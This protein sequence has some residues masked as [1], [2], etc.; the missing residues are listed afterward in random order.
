MYKNYSSNCELR[1]LAVDKLTGYNISVGGDHAGKLE[2]NV[3]PFDRW[4]HIGIHLDTIFFCSAYLA[5]HLCQVDDPTLFSYEPAFFVNRGTKMN[6]LY[7]S[8]SNGLVQCWRQE[9][10]PDGKSYRTV[11]GKMDGKEVMSTWQSPTIKNV[12]KKNETT[13]EQQV[14]KE[15]EANY[16]MKL[17]QGNYKESLDDIG[18]DN[19]FKPLLAKTYGKDYI[20]TLKDY[21]NNTYSQPKLD[22]VRCI[23]TIDGMWSRQGKPILSAPHIYESFKHIFEVYPDL[24]LDGELYTHRLKDNFDYLISLVRKS[25]PTQQDL[26]ECAQHIQ[27]W[28]YDTY[29]EESFENRRYWI[30]NLAEKINSE[31]LVLVPTL[32]IENQQQLDDVYGEYLMDGYEGQMVRVGENGYEHKRSKQ[33]LKRKEFIDEE[34]IIHDIKEGIGNRSGMAGRIE[35]VLPDGRVVGAGIKGGFALYEE[36]WKNKG[37]YIDTLVTIRYQNLTPDGVPRFA[38]ATKFW[39]EKVRSL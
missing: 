1:Y 3:P 14:L 32:K 4:Y 9:I 16:K 30:L 31:Y 35:Y 13:I 10:S 37:N 11:T 29:G 26:D 28:V 8:T 19:Y 7:K 27:Y 22:G 21:Q 25:K 39:K 18:T 24:I 15:V 5:T 36:L 33:L 12:G 23:L 17:N 20:P 6:T 34:F 2:F 38:V